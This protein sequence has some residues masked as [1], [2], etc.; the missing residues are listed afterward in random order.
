MLF[1]QLA[2]ASLLALAASAGT[3][4]AAAAYPVQN[5]GP[6]PAPGAPAAPAAGAPAAPAAGAPAA[7]AAGGATPAAGAGKILTVMVGQGGTTFI[8]NNLT[9]SVGDTVM[10]KWAP[11]TGNHTVTQSTRDNL[12]A[13]KDQTTS[14]ASGIHAGPQNFSYNITVND[15]APIWFFCAVL[16]HCAKGGMYGVVNGPPGF[17]F[18]VPNATATNPGGSGAPVP[19]GT[20]AADAAAASKP[21]S[22]AS[23]LVSF[24]KSAVFAGAIAVA[25]FLL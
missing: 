15:T 20:G 16:Q 4:D 12:C 22:A 2:A 10:F 7:P 19:S 11:A 13:R 21:A 17:T 23:S 3:V 9:A 24:S 25:A 14:F 1:K 5:A 6:T 8:P 18:N